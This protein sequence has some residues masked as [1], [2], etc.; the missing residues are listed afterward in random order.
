M[1]DDEESIN[2]IGEHNPEYSDTLRVEI[3]GSEM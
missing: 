3:S 2:R 1:A